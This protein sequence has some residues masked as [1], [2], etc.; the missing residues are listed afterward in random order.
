MER[1]ESREIRGAVARSGVG[2]RECRR[3][4]AIYSNAGVSGV[5][6]GTLH[7]T[8]AGACVRM[9]IISE[10]EGRREERGRA[11]KEARM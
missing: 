11:G 9:H 5:N 10:G 4:R 6:A 1:N 7:S 8:R 3:S 2:E